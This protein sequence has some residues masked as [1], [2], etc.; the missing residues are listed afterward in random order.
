MTTREELQEYLSLLRCRNL[1]HQPGDMLEVVEDPD[2]LEAYSK[3]NHVRLGICYRSKWHIMVVDLV[4]NSAGRL[5][6][7][8]RLLKTQTGSSVVVIP[9]HG[10]K[11]VLLHQYRHAM[12][13]YQYC[14]PRGFA[15]AGISPLENARKEIREELNC[16]C[17][18][19]ESLGT[20]VADSGICGEPVWI[21]QCEIQA[22]AVDGI[23]ESIASYI[24]VTDEELEKMIRDGMITD[25]FTL[26]AAARMK[27][28][29]KE[30]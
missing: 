11:L 19:V 27:C 9:R 29:S 3:E 16:G 18:R 12:S 1:I 17:D 7:Y 6:T 25:G 15:E 23:Y 24:E 10:E 13:G 21:C 14:F 22:P 30:K 20:M 8:E 5:F 4:R 2:M 28:C 26:S